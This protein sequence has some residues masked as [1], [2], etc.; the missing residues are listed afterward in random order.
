MNIG[1]FSGSF[2]PIHQGHLMIANYIVEFS[3]LDEIWFVVS[4]QNPLKD[5]A[6]LADQHHRLQMVKLALIGY[7]N[8][9]ASDFEF[10]LPVPSYS[11][12]TLNALNLAYPQHTFSLV[13]GADNWALFE[14]WKSYEDIV[15]NYRIYVYD[16]LNYPIRI[17]VRFRQ[18]VE[19]LD[20]PIIEISSTFIR[21][22]L[23]EGKDVK[24][25]VPP[26]VWEYLLEKKLYHREF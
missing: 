16:R 17:P 15:R 1:I 11:I 6:H 21:Q 9:I 8:L 24:A 5:K 25:F 12:D 4:P 7:N 3:S 22:S 26:K 14:N 10:Y 13:I 19:T 23:S 2:N 20:S 18:Q